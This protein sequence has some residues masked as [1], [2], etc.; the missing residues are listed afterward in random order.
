MQ[1]QGSS[2]LKNPWKPRPLLGWVAKTWQSSREGHLNDCG[3]D[4][5]FNR[6][7][8]CWEGVWRKLWIGTYSSCVIVVSSWRADCKH[9]HTNCWGFQIRVGAAPLGNFL[10]P[11]KNCCPPRPTSKKTLYLHSWTPLDYKFHIESSSPSR[12]KIQ[13][14]CAFPISK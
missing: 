6:P 1:C 8:F 7:E 13:H 5:L 12:S 14:I 4:S 9:P 2:T 10:N 3:F 11:T